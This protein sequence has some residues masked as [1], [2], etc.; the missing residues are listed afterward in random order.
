M[1]WTLQTAQ[2]HLD[3]WLQAELAIATSQ[4]YTIGTRRL[5]R[6][7]LDEVRQQIKFWR[8]EVDR[9]KCGRRRGARVMRAVPRDL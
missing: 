8:N 3:T 7:D 4:E 6:A 5:R 2:T 9:L 1:S